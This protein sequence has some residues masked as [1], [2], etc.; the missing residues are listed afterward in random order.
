M[1]IISYSSDSSLY[2][3]DT[4][5]VITVPA[6]G[7]ASNRVPSSYAWVGV[8]WTRSFQNKGPNGFTKSPPTLLVF[9]YLAVNPLKWLIHLLYNTVLIVH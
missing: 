9:G 1:F 3:Q 4:K 6:D 8:Q 7:L 5:L 2:T